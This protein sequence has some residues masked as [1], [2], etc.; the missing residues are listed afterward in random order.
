[1]LKTY[2]I[3]ITNHQIKDLF[4]LWIDNGF[5]SERN[6]D[7]NK[8]LLLGLENNV[9]SIK[10]YV[11]ESNSFI[12]SSAIIL[13]NNQNPSISALGEVCTSIKSRGNGYAS[14]LCKKIVEDYFSIDKNEVIFL[15]TVNPVAKKIYESL[16]WESISNSDVMFNSK[17]QKSFE[18]FLS[19]YYAS[20]LEKKISNGN[21]NF[22][23]SIIPFVLSLRSTHQI[24]LNSN[25]N[26]INISSGCLSLYNKFDFIDEKNGKWFCIAN[27][28]NNIFSVASFLKDES[29][30]FRLDGLFN[31]LWHKESLKL[32]KYIIGQLKN[33]TP[34]SIYVEIYEKDEYKFKLFVE[35]GFIVKESYKKEIEGKELVFNKLNL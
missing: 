1:M 10:L 16:G 11:F 35:L 6:I 33:E 19:E 20:T 15:G 2:T 32:M 26:L 30:N 24:D 27:N 5:E 31:T 13:S 3:P 12:Q 23:L 4:N 22:R 8:N 34:K 18:S 21:S 29:N 9:N 7:I 17:S 28:E 25:I 14:K